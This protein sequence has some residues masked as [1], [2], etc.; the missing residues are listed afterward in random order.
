[1]RDREKLVWTVGFGAVSSGGRPE[2]DWFVAMFRHV[3]ENLGLVRWEYVRAVFETVL[4][5]GELD[6]EG[7][8]LWDEMGIEQIV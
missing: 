3:C 7:V 8:R 1:M 6:A 4:W 2:R 5:K